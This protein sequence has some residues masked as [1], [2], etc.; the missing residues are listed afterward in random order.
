MRNI[1]EL[2]ELD[3]IAKMYAKMLKAENPIVIDEFFDSDAEEG[4]Y[5]AN[6]SALIGDNYYSGIF[7]LYKYSNPCIDLRINNFKVKGL[8]LAQVDTEYL[9]NIETN[10]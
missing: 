9:K 7:T 10:A 8:S 4:E 2:R 5:Y 6:I 1:K 3:K